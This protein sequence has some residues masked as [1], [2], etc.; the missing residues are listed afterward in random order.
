MR[1]KIKPKVER[2]LFDIFTWHRWYAWY[3][4]KIDLEWVWLEDVERKYYI[5]PSFSNGPFGTTR[6]AGEIRERY[7]MYRN[8]S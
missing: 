1:W 7:W 2:Q 4:V 5:E 8:D 6:F 3:P